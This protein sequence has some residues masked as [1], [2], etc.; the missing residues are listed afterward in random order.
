MLMTDNHRHDAQFPEAL[1]RYLGR[2]LHD[3]VDVR[4]F[5]VGHS[6][7]SFIEQT[8]TLYETRILGRYCVIVANLADAGTPSDIAKHI[9]IVSNVTHTTAVFAAWAIRS[10]NRSR[11]IGHGIPFIIPGNQLYFPDL[12]IDIREHFRARKS[13]ETK[14]LSP[15]AQAVL[16]YRILNQ[17]AGPPAPSLLAERLHY[18]VMSIS[19]AFDDLVTSGLATTIKQGKERHIRFKAEGRLLLGA[20]APLLRSPVRSL[21]F[22][23]GNTFASLK[24]AGETA[25]SQLTGLA[26]P[27]I[28]TF[29]VGASN[30]K[31]VSQNLRLIEVSREEADHIVEAWSYDPAALSDTPVVDALSLYAQFRDHRD[32]RVAMAADQLLENLPC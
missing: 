7:P 27:R 13:L 17:A 2:V 4:P 5:G 32:E 26:R 23:R 9:G 31:E 3:R 8:Y 29:A 14:E 11:L 19:R 16:F 1:E 12:A 30:W 25:L 10:Y 24:V 22:V 20:A 6:L 28:D 18:S 21:K 15:A